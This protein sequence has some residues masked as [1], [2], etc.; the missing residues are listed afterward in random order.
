M[1]I[2]IRLDAIQYKAR[3]LGKLRLKKPN[4]I[5]SIHSI[6]LFV[7]AV[8][9]SVGGIVVVF[10]SSHVEPPT[11]IGITIGDVSGRP[12]SSHKNE[13]SIGITRW[14]LGSHE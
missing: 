8:R 4:I 10:W 9:S 5:G 7:E 1:T 12:K 14:T 11:S 6:I 3:P 2:P 13:A